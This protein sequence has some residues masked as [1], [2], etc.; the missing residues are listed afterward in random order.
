MELDTGMMDEF[1]KVANNKELSGKDRDQAL[2]SMY[3]E[4]VQAAKDSQLEA[5]ETVREGWKKESENHKEFG[6]AQYKENKGVMMNALTEF[7]SP[8]L[9]KMGEQFGWMDNPHFQSFLFNVGKKFVE[10]KTNSGG[11]GDGG[12]E[13]IENRWYGED[14]NDK[15]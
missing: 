15:A 10:G 12:S 3:A 9:V 2:V 1:L 14:G 6:G 8:D 11:G 13:T 7:G 4:K 5:W